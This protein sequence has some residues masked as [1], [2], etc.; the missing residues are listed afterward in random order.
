MNCSLIR[1]VMA[2]RRRVAASVMVRAGSCSDC[3]CV[4]TGRSVGAY[5]VLT[6]RSYSWREARKALGFRASACK[7]GTVLNMQIRGEEGL[8]VVIGPRIAQATWRG[9]KRSSARAAQ[10]V[11]PDSSLPRPGR[12]R[13][14]V[15]ALTG[16]LPAA[17]RRLPLCSDPRARG[18]ATARTS[19]RI[20]G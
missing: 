13:G 20:R 14:N 12:C 4:N 5:R 19:C 16:F 17:A 8:A 3:G 15:A 2:L 7:R 10:S 11:R 18:H 9:W 1:I 6:E